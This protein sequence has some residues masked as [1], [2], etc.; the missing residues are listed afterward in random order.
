MWYELR[1]I[2]LFHDAVHLV[3][4]IQNSLLNY[5][6]FIFPSFKFDCF[7]DPINVPGGEMEI[8]S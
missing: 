3:K 7:K 5:I 8:F 6:W 2:Y 1:K 4:S